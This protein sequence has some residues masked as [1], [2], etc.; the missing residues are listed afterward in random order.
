M[1]ISD[2]KKTRQIYVGSVAVGGGST[3]SVQSMTKT[4]TRNVQATGEQIRYLE[5]LGCDIIRLAV[6]DM[7]AARA[8]GPIKEAVT[9]PLIADIHFDWRLALEALTQGVDGLR[10]NPG[11]IGAP[12]KIK[13][14]V[15]AASERSV[16]IRIGVNAGSEAASTT[17]F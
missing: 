4:D 17:S 6:P 9:I 16:P 10:L 7:E 5:S 11:N 3:I 13:E 1:S 15:L 14:V 2:R 8:L 12:W